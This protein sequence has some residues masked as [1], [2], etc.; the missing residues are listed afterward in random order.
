MRKRIHRL[1]GLVDGLTNA[2]AAIAT[3]MTA[4]MIFA[5]L[6]EIVSRRF[7]GAPTIWSNDVSYMLNGSVFML[8]TAYTLRLDGHVRIDFLM[9][10]MPDRLRHAVQAGFYLLLF[11]PALGLG[12]R[13]AV[14]K[15]ERAFVRG[16]LETASAWEPLIWP[17]LTGLAIGMGMLFL[18]ALAEAVR[19]I[20]AIGAPG[21]GVAGDDAGGD[22]AAGDDAAGNQPGRGPQTPAAQS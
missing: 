11:L 14:L 10:M 8:G 17:F 5:M 18:Q 13:Y 21:E 6:Y 1:L 12:T 7:F 16:S 9:Q 15:A 20:L 3:V 19:H 2:L 4:I 22:D